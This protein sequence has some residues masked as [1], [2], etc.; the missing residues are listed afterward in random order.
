M[1]PIDNRYKD[2]EARAQATRDLLKS[3]VDYRMS[4]DLIPPEDREMVCYGIGN[5]DYYKSG[6]KLR[7][8]YNYLGVVS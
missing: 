1:D 2:E 8:K 6:T 4:I 5:D 3:V 7:Y